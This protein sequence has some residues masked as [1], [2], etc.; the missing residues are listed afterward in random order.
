MVLGQAGAQ[1]VLQSAEESAQRRNAPSAIALVDLAGGSAGFPT[2]GQYPGGQRGTRHPEARPAARISGLT[3]NH[4]EF[5]H[6]VTKIKMIAAG[7][8]GEPHPFEIGRET[9]SAISH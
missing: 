9:A 4:S 7:K 5:D 8:P 2:D 1:T 6:A 3:S